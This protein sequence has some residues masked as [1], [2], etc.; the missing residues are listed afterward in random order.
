MECR[1]QFISSSGWQA[2]GCSSYPHFT[3]KEPNT[4]SDLQKVVQS[5]RVEAA[6]DV[7]LITMASFSPLA[8]GS[9]MGE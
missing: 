6:A 2:A 1:Y 4:Q 7:G 3:D 9:T 5:G 8:Q